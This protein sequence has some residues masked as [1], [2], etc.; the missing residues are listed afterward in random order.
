MDQTKETLYEQIDRLKLFLLEKGYS[1]H[2]LRHYSACWNTL[3]SY[4]GSEADC[5]YSKELGKRFL[6][7]TLK[8]T[9]SEQFS[10]TDKKFIQAINYLETFV[11]YGALPRFSKRVSL[12]P[13]PFMDVTEEYISKL[14]SVNQTH[15]SIKS[16]KSRLRQFLEF[17]DDKSIHG[18]GDIDKK[19]IIEFMAVLKPKYS[20]AARSNILYTVIDFLIFCETAGYISQ[21]MSGLI[22]GIYSN[23]NETLPTTYNASEIAQLLMSID[24]SSAKG[25][26]D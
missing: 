11:Y 21:E 10:A 20:S 22:K 4:A 7:E 15:K 5:P 26:K 19:H 16:K 6:S 9:P 2:T 3:M 8:A 18:T 24:R 25:K 14:H 23:P 13:E 12:A 17:L 1:P